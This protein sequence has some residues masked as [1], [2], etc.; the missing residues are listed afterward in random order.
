MALACGNMLE[1]ILSGRVSG[2]ALLRHTSSLAANGGSA[3]GV[4]HQHA[5]Y[6]TNTLFN[7]A[8]RRLPAF[9]SSGRSEP[10]VQ[11]PVLVDAQGVLEVA[12]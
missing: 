10:W 1:A 8:D 5:L 12:G 6:D 7:N 11:S 2:A 4:R 9:A 3:D